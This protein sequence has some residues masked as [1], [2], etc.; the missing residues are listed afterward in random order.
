MGE[1]KIAVVT[2]EEGRVCLS[3][4]EP[5]NWITLTP[6]QAIELGKSLIKHAGCRVAV[7]GRRGQ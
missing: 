7:K 5:I 3:W 2:D 4:E 6:T 1:P